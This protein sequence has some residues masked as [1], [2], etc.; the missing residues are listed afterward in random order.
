MKTRYSIPAFQ[1][2][3]MIGMLL[4]NALPAISQTSKHEEPVTQFLDK[5][6]EVQSEPL[7]AWYT[8]SAVL[9]ENGLYDVNVYTL[10]GELVMSGQY[11][12][13]SLTIQDGL[14]KYYYAN[15]MKESEGMYSQG[16]KV[17]P[18]KRWD[19]NGNQKPDRIYPTD[20]EE[21]MRTI[22]DNN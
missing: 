1:A 17:G 16:T 19:M 20:S 15:G 8:S 11:T 4:S 2:L 18:W 14:F 13:A 12:D 10:G 6:R 21:M 7:N 5:Y 22:A 3:M 9:N